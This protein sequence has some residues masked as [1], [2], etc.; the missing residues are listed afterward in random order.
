VDFA[1][2][3]ISERSGSGVRDP[4]LCPTTGEEADGE[5]PQAR[6]RKV[7]A[8]LKTG[9]DER[10]A[11][12]RGRHQRICRTRTLCRLGR[13]G[14]TSHLSRA[15]RIKR[16]RKHHPAALDG[17]SHRALVGNRQPELHDRAASERALNMQATAALCSET[18]CHG[19][20]EAS[21]LANCLGRKERLR[22]PS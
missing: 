13:R 12:Y 22:G 17:G 10:L 14:S 7:P 8:P 2:L 19:Q 11:L 15:W 1:G 4:I 6:T 21:A 18:V 20:P 5:Q 16:R 3:S 9:E